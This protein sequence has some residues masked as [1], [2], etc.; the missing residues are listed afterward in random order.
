MYSRYCPGEPAT[1]SKNSTLEDS[2]DIW[3]VLLA[4]ALH[5]LIL[6]LQL[7]KLKHTECMLLTFR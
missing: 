5:P 7:C 1:L 2:A 4:E 6:S 3:T